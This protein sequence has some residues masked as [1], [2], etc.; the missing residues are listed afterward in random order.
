MNKE[1]SIIIPLKNRTKISVDYE[2]IPLRVLQRNDLLPSGLVRK[3]INLTKDNKIILDLLLNFL[4]SISNMKQIDESIEI[5]LTDFDSDDYDLSLLQSNFPTLKIKIINESSHFSRGKGLNIGYQ[6]STMKNVFFCDAD[7]LVVTRELLDNA[8]DELCVG[9]VFFPIC[10]GL[11]EPSHQFGYW[12]KSGY[13]MCFIK[14]EL[15]IKYNY[16]WSE[17]N[18]LGKEDDDF[19]GFFN[20]LGLCSR[21]QVNGYYH[22]WHPESQ[23]FKNRYYKYNDIKRKKILINCSHSDI[24]SDMIQNIIK[25]LKFAHDVY[26]TYHLEKFVTDVVFIEG[27]KNVVD[28]DEINEYMK[29]HNKNLVR[30]KINMYDI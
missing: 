1:L 18:S 22:Q 6:N 30:H 12:R 13:G 17:Y 8:Y 29:K 7:M 25:K 28:D 15:L 16:I 3:Q 21:Y 2:P 5:V 11:C 10:F 20:K 27:I 19:W 9:K 23:E 4:E 24:S 14:K 26:T